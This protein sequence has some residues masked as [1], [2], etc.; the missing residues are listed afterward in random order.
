M[1]SY[2]VV[3][4]PTSEHDVK[5]R[6]NVGK[7]IG[8]QKL[9]DIGMSPGEGMYEYRFQNNY[10]EVE[11]ASCGYVA[12]LQRSWTSVLFED[13]EAWDFAEKVLNKKNV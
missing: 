1:G 10:G 6:F 5:V 9:E 4:N 13:E 8:Q 2:E 7:N 3:E 12:R 11:E